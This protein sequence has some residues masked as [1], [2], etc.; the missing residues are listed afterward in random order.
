[1]PPKKTQLKG[2]LI[3]PSSV[4]LSLMKPST[5]ELLSNSQNSYSST[6]Y[7]NIGGTTAAKKDTKVLCKTKKR[8]KKPTKK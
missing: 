7:M 1:M 2:G 6:N 5:V 4:T 8:A 3:D